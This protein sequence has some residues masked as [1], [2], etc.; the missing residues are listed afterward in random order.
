MDT[1]EP[2]GP[3]E[4]VAAEARYE[5]LVRDA[6]VAAMRLAE[7]TT[8][9]RAN[10]ER[11]VDAIDVPPPSE[12]LLKLVVDSREPDPMSVLLC[13][14]VLRRSVKATPYQD[15]WLAIFGCAAAKAVYDLR[16]LGL[17]E[18]RLELLD[19]LITRPQEPIS[20]AELH[21]QRAITRRVLTVQDDNA[22]RMVSADL[23][24]A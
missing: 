23:Q 10:V 22:M 24:V 12:A 9:G 20:L 21:F 6:H 19:E 15:P 4:V 11:E 5:A 8:L 2:D 3:A 17:F 14:L 16:L 7:V 13:S 18:L 1:T